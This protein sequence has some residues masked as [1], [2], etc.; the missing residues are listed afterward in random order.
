MNRACIQ[1]T[2]FR[3]YGY[4]DATYGYRIWDDHGQ[5]YNNCMEEDDLKL[6]D[7]EFLRKASETFSEAADM[8]FEYAMEH[9]IH[10]DGR[11]YQFDRSGGMWRLVEQAS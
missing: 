1:R 8:I 10:V 6:S 11:W 5:D 7:E 2:E 4:L 3:S 9:G